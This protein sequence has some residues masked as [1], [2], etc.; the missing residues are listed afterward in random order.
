MGMF[1][2]NNETSSSISLLW[3]YC[4]DI[5]EASGVI[6]SVS[7]TQVGG[8]THPELL[9]CT[10]MDTFAPLGACLLY[11]FAMGI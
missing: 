3:D 10:G 7:I 5:A 4:V 1:T 8:P 11:P 2:A 9:V 6:Q